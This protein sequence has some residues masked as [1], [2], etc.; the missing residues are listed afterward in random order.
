MEH[1]RSN[2][3]KPPTPDLMAG[4]DAARRGGTM[5]MGVGEREPPADAVTITRP[6]TA[7]AKRR[8]LPAVTGS[9][10]ASTA[11]FRNRPYTRSRTRRQ[12]RETHCTEPLSPPSTAVGLPIA[13]GAPPEPARTTPGRLGRRD[14]V[15]PRDPTG[16]GCRSLRGDLPRSHHGPG[17]GAPADIQAGAQTYVLAHRRPVTPSGPH[18]ERFILRGGSA[19]APHGPHRVAHSTLHDPTLTNI[20]AEGRYRI[21]FV[22]SLRFLPVNSPVTYTP[23]CHLSERH[24]APYGLSSR[25]LRPVTSHERRFHHESPQ[26]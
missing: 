18:R 17:R 4:A 12:R 2:G 23:K 26:R 1:H 20:A 9:R 5:G 7:P 24:D 25:R 16:L 8:R 21:V 3:N 6:R 10:P 15:C 19:R 22:N 13:R 11:S 14:L